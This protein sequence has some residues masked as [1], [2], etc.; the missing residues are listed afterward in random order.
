MKTNAMKMDDKTMCIVLGAVTS[1][2]AL[3]RL[4]FSPG[5]L[6]PF[7][8]NPK[9]MLLMIWAPARQQYTIENLLFVGP[10]GGAGREN[11]CEEAYL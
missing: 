4:Y 5:S 3:C 7:V 6:L 2:S 11:C 8:V 9:S 10:L 1:S